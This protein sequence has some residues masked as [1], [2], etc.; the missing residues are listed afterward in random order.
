VARVWGTS[1]I[2]SGQRLGL[3]AAPLYGRWDP[4]L[5]LRITAAVAVAIAVV[6][7]GPQ[8]ARRAR[9]GTLVVAAGMTTMVW[10]VSLALVD[11]A[12]AITAPL[13]GRHEQLPFARDVADVGTFVDTFTERIAGYPIHVQ[14]HPPASVVLFALLDRVGLA[15]SGWVAV[16]VITGGGV[17]VAATL[18][19]TRSLAGEA[20]ARAAAPFLVLLPAAIWIASTVDAL[21]AGVG[22]GGVA[23]IALAMQRRRTGAAWLALTGGAA[24]GLAVHLSY[25]LVLIGAL[26]F[27]LAWRHRCIRPVVWASIGGAAVT[28]G[29]LVAG[30]AW[31]EGL[32][33]THE[34][35]TAGIA[36]TRP[37]GYS[38][39]G[40]LAALA[41]ASGP[42]VA[43]GLARWRSVATALVAPVIGAV[44]IADLLGLSK[45]EV[46]RIWL[47]LVVPLA[48]AAGAVATRARPWLA[49]QATAAITLASWLRTP[50]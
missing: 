39:V 8:L 44:V 47:F 35:Y 33:A 3:R 2:S 19:V 24:L 26:V 34:R 17:A 7:R 42:V 38:L 15:G 50:W 23:L 16:L 49:L 9:F 21:Y 45:G 46:E 10:S 12:D 30:F 43:V 11:G 48:V 5:T 40:N 25:G 6:W 18:V 27:A 32:A 22:L 14:G 20:A 37:Y 4:V 28:V 29:F 1:I 41:L 31:W 36:S 13:V